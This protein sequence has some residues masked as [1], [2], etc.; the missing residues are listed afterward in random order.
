MPVDDLE[1]GT[2]ETS[3]SEDVELLSEE[4]PEE[5]PEEVTD[6]ET[7][8]EETPDEEE[9]SE[10]EEETEEEPEEDEDEDKITRPSWKEIKDKHPELAKNKDFREMFHRERAFSDLFP[11]LE[12]ARDASEK[13]QALDFFDSSL[14]E[15]KPEVLINSL[16][17]NEAIANKFADRII[18]ALY[19]ANPKLFQRAT[20]PLMVEMLNAVAERAN[21]TKD[22]NLLISAKNIAKFLFGKFEIPARENRINPELEN[23]KKQLQ[24]ERAR[25]I[26]N[27]RNDFLSRADKSISKQLSKAITE[28]L[29]PK[30]ELSDFARQALI[31]K[32]LAETRHTLTSDK[33]FS[34]KIQNLVRLAEKSGFPQD[35]LPR[36]ISAYLG[37]A[38]TTA[39][40][41]RAKYKSAA[42]EKRTAPPKTRIEGSTEKQTPQTSTKGDKAKKSDMDIILE[43]T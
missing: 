21:G 1:T 42:V 5:T 10:D 33:A 28:G 6:D 15:G 23:E 12:D 4:T 35:Y 2:S 26:D 25:L 9:P 16:A 7:S 24:T 13:A 8:D 38:K 3:L 32:V 37:R 43:G 29:D 30:N 17:S 31:E 19:A 20:Q 34:S 36:L 27:Q 40:T 39:L 41:L 11:T 14:Q 22:D 18:P